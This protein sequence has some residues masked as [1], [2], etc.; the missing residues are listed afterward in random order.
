MKTK[1]ILLIHGAFAGG[2]SWCAVIQ[3]LQIKAN[4]MYA[5]IDSSHVAMVSHPNFVTNL[6]IRASAA[7][8]ERMLQ[9]SP[10][11]RNSP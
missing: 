9:K 1:N 5:E 3:R 7:A 6:V 4:V 8:A 2:S 11:A 10:S